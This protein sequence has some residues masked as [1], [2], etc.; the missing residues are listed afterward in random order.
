[1]ATHPLLTRNST[2]EVRRGREREALFAKMWDVV[3]EKHEDVET[4]MDTFL[5]RELL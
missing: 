2:T 1:M 5:H 4:F 3:K